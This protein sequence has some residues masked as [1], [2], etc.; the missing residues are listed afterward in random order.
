MSL[1][2]AFR[3]RSRAFPIVLAAL[4]VLCASACKDGGGSGDLP[5]PEVETIR[6]AAFNIQVFGQT[7]AGKPDVMSTLA[8]IAQEFDVMVVQEIRDASEQVADQFLARI[9]QDADPDYAMYE[10]PREGRTSSKEQYVV[11]YLPSRVQFVSASV[12]Q[13]TNDEF[14]REPLIATFKAG[15]FDFTLVVCHIKPDSADVELGHMATVAAS[16]L[17]ANPNEQDIILLGDFNADGSYWDEDKTNHPLKDSSFH[18]VIG[19]EWDT[20]VAANTYTYDRI[21][22]KP[23]T[24]NFEY[25]ADSAKVFYFD[26]EYGL[27]NPDYVKSVSDHYP[28][29]AEFKITG[30]DDDGS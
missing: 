23:A 25:I 19:N 14:E 1:L 30:P 24:Y 2:D 11:Y 4:F 17:A 7:K 8:Q 16:V 18:W 21:I 3:N 27:T 26:Q 5:K 28:V 20:T 10:S 12:Y 13:E 9:N 6:I 22:L 29:F 15:E